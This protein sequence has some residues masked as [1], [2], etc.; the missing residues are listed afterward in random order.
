M[1]NFVTHEYHNVEPDI[2][3]ETLQTS[4]PELVEALGEEPERRLD[5]RGP[6]TG[7]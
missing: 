1:R 6:G 5:M 2:V 7:P 4:I 3:R